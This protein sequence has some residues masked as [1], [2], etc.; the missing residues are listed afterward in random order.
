M[1]QEKQSSSL[2]LKILGSAALAGLVAIL[3][4]IWAVYSSRTQDSAM[5]RQLANQA[6]Q[7]AMQDVQI[8][9]N[10]EQN[11]LLA[12]QAVFVKR[13]GNHFLNENGTT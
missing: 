1:A 5:E 4:L 13:K 6:T 8:D 10:A 2:F 12:E 11:R 3:A 9:L 7:I